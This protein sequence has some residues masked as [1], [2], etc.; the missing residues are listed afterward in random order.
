MEW[1][2]PVDYSS[3]Q[4]DVIAKRQPG[5]GE[6]LLTSREFKEFVREPGKTMLCPGIPGAGK[7]VLAAT[8]IDHLQ[9]AFQGDQNIAV[10]YLYFNYQVQ[11]EQSH[12]A[13]LRCL[14]K[15][16]IELQPRASAEVEKL[17]SCHKEKRTRPSLDEGSAAFSVAVRALTNIYLVMDALDEYHALDPSDLYGWLNHIFTLQ[18]ASRF[19]I[20]ATSRPISEILAKFVSPIRKDIEAHEDG[21]E[22]YIDTG[23]QRLLGG[24]LSSQS[25]LQELVKK[26][27][28]N[29]T[30]GMFLLAKLHM[31]SL[32]GQARAGDLK[33]ALRNL[34]QGSDRL[35]KT[36]DETLKRIDSQSESNRRLGRSILCWITYAER[37]LLAEELGEAVA[38]EENDTELDKD[39]CVDP[40]D[41][42]SYCA[43]LI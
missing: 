33:R 15:Q 35:D 20:L 42:D 27:V 25:S 43:G 16:L 29:A 18:Q 24:K 17:M 14:I 4:Q 30:K 8:I 11:Q 36:Y 34:P 41:I 6:W 32:E 19:N 3:Q 12:K 5:T 9:T 31:D 26:Q 40:S 22:S 37:P 10:V 39:F 7:T 28:L 21:I 1:L 2:S 23:K 38:V 13:L